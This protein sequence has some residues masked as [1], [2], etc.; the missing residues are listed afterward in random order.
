[1][2]RIVDALVGLIPAVDVRLGRRV[3]A[4][5]HVGDGVR[6]VLDDGST[7][8]ADAAIV[9]T[10]AHV[11]APLLAEQFPTVGELLGAIDHSSVAMLTIA[12]DDGLIGDVSGASGCLIPRDQGTIATAVSFATSKWAQLRSPERG[13]VIL[14][15]SAGRV[16]D[17]R[18]R[19][20]DDDALTEAVLRD[21]DRVVGLHGQPT[22]IRIGR[23]ERSLPQYAPGHLDRIDQVE[24]ALAGAPIVLAGMALRGVGIPACVHGAEQAAARLGATWLTRRGLAR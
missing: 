5:E 9:T 11:A 6:A 2:A 10:P 17:D 4:L 21:L 20:L 23:W 8:D 7:I 14:R 1:M 12:V 18:Q 16:G 13:D 22:E 15:A 19:D 3:D 24:A